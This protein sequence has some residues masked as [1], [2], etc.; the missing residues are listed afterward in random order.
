MITPRGGGC[1]PDA[2]A[3][4]GRMRTDPLSKTD[5]IAV[6][7]TMRTDVIARPATSTERQVAQPASSECADPM[8]TRCTRS[9]DTTMINTIM[10]TSARRRVQDRSQTM[11]ETVLRRHGRR[12]M[13]TAVAGPSPPAPP[14]TQVLEGDPGRHPSLVVA[15]YQA[16]DL[17]EP[18][19]SC[20][21]PSGREQRDG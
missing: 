8:S 11:T 5:G 14:W 1:L 17:I 15:R 16:S 9:K 6:D 21:Y 7:H 4:C 10:P 20:R 2:M 3:Q 13:A 19:D 18:L 12:R